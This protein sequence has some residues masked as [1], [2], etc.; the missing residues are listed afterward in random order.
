[1]ENQTP[2]NNLKKI[3]IEKGFSQKEFYEDIIKK[4]LGLNITLRTYH[5]W[6][7]LNNE[8]K[9]KPAL[10]LAEYFGVSIGYLLGHESDDVLLNTLSKKIS[11]LSP[12]EF[13]EYTQ[14]DEYSDEKKLFDHLFT[15]L[16]DFN[17]KSMR[18]RKIKD[19]IGLLKGLDLD[20][21]NLING[22]VERLY[23][24]DYSLDDNDI[25]DN[26]RKQLYDELKL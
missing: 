5:N 3:R 20:D 23:F 13:V 11:S 7:N 4:E 8:I 19:I 12:E 9:S 14:T 18:G 26:K 25:L 6:E 17:E 16:Q 10:L 24:S 2:K 22:F 21:L 1:M 15:K